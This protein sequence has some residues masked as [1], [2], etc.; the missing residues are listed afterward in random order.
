MRPFFIRWQSFFF[1]TMVFGLKEYNTICHV[2]YHHHH[3]AS[4]YLEPMKPA[5]ASFITQ[6]STYRSSMCQLL[7]CEWCSVV[8]WYGSGYQKFRSICFLVHKFC[9]VFAGILV[10]LATPIF[11]FHRSA[12]RCDVL[13]KNSRRANE[14]MLHKFKAS[15]V[16]QVSK[17]TCWN[18]I[19]SQFNWSPY[20]C[21]K[22]TRKCCHL[23]LQPVRSVSQMVNMR[24]M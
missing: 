18:P 23:C 9:R 7:P 16:K 3:P 1:S 4:S 11:I 6:P 19:M 24:Q 12:S 5:C 14:D 2:L 22:Q 15:S 13:Q 20:G 17:R 8:S 21:N 10:T